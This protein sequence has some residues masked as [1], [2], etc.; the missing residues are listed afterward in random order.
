MKAFRP[1]VEHGIVF[2]QTPTTCFKYNGWPTVCRDENGVLY[3]AA[4]SMRMSHVD[5]TGKDCMWIS[6]NEGK[7]W[8]PPLVIHDSYFDDRDAGIVYMGKGRMLLS[9]FSLCYE[10]FCD[11]IQSYDWFPKPDKAISKGFGESWKCLSKE[12]RV[13]G[14]G[15]FVKVSEDYGMTWSAPVRVPLT[16]PH[17]PTVCKDG[18]LVYMGKEMD[19][20]YEAPNPIVLYT[21]KDGGYTWTHTGTVPPGEDITVD[22]MHEPHVVELPGGRL[23]GAIRVHERKAQPDFTVYTTYSDD[24]GKTWSVPVCI[25]VD[26]S[27][28]HLLVHSSGAVICSYG[29]RRG[30]GGKKDRR[31]EDRSERACV[32]YD[33]GET[34]TEDYCLNDEIDTQLDMG[35]P[36]SVEL[37]DGSIMTVYYQCW[38]GDWYTSVLYTKWRLNGK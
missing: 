35:Y 14:T 23:L 29:R 6:Q 9:Y 25:G 30:D 15:A 28:P 16:A 12:E 22:N 19:P 11:G 24:R 8:S 18:T 1:E 17:G 5:P 10:D 27:P 26:G 4:S 34:W 3:A 32:S 21:S 31:P 13:K 37:S 20:E 33:G 38:P 2:R 36:A 7:T